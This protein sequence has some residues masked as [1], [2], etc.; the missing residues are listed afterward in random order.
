VIRQ[1][2][3]RDEVFQRGCFRSVEFELESQ[4]ETTR[5][6]GRFSQKMHHVFGLDL[7]EDVPGMSLY[8][9]EQECNGHATQSPQH[10]ELADIAEAG[11]CAVS[12]AR[13][14]RDL[15]PGERRGM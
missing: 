5:H 13:L 11:A 10:I 12:A 8:D 2:A 14:F 6:L 3:P 15:V 7:G 9:I 1:N 4:A